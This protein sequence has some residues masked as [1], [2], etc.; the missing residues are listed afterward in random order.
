MIP[1]GWGCPRRIGFLFPH[2]CDRLTP[3]GCPHC[4]NGQIDDPYA[5]RLDRDEYID[6]DSY[7]DSMVAGAVGRRAMNFNEADGENLVHPEEEFEDDMTES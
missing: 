2:P 1:P 5:R 7:D 3:I 4:D 6:Y